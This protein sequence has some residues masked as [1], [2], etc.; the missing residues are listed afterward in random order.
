VNFPD[1]VIKN[2]PHDS[3]VR[4]SYTDLKKMAQKELGMITA[5]EH[6]K[7]KID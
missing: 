4:K 5:I 2:E 7:F 6:P 1:D 3:P